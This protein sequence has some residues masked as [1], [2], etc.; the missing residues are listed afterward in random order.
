MIKYI[1]NYLKLPLKCLDQLGFLPQSGSQLELIVVFS[2]WM[3]CVDL[4]EQ[5]FFLYS[6]S[7]GKLWTLQAA[8]ERNQSQNK[9]ATICCW[10]PPQSMLERSCFQPCLP[11]Q[12][13]SKKLWKTHWQTILPWHYVVLTNIEAS[14]LYWGESLAS[15][16]CYS[17]CLKKKKIL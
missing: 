14:F 3:C 4:S 15:L 13:S 12:I 7:P 9:A 2:S 10:L 6:S 8:T 17:I 1:L 5:L 16:K 11:V